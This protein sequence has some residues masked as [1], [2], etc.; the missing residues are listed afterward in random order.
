MAENWICYLPASYLSTVGVPQVPNHRISELPE[1]QLPVANVVHGY[2]SVHESPEFFD[3]ERQEVS[4]V[5]LR[6]IAR[7]NLT[8]I[9]VRIISATI[10]VWVTVLGTVAPWIKEI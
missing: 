7:S 9:V 2:E 3:K 10:T 1:A 4:E 8:G 5:S 6:Q